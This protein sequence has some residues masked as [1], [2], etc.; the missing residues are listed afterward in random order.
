MKDVKFTMPIIS[1]F[2][3]DGSGKTTLARVLVRELK[4]R[5]VNAFDLLDEGYTHASKHNC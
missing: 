4:R 3:P 1:F 2:G 5:G